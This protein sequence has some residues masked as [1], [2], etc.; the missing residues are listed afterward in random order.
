MFDMFNFGWS[1]VDPVPAD[2]DGDGAADV[3]VYHEA[4]GTWYLLRS[5]AGFTVV[6]F[7]G[8]GMRPVE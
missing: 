4:G 3:A 5:S 1:Q 2:Y 6:P 8:P 7:G